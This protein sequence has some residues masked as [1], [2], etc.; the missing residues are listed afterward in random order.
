[1]RVLFYVL[2]LLCTSCHIRAVGGLLTGIV[3]PATAT[4]APPERFK[5]ALWNCKRCDV[6]M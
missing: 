1:M 3:K 4:S 2:R 6:L 5:Q